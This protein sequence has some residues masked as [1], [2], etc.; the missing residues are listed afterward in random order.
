MKFM[1]YMF[2]I[3]GC[4]RYSIKFVIIIFVFEYK[5]YLC[6]NCL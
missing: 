3:E 4:N 1:E 6:I 5:N 2:Y